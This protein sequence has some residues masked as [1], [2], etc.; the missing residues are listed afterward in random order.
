MKN[1]DEMYCHGCNQTLE[2]IYLSG[3]NDLR[4]S[5]IEEIYDEGIVLNCGD[6]YCHSD[7]LRDCSK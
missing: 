5:S 7:C 3:A 2:E 4:R 6:W 1:Y